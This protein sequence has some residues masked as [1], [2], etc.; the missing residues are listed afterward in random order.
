MQP[1]E[2]LMPKFADEEDLI[3]SSDNTLGS[4][5]AHSASKDLDICSLKLIGLHHRFQEMETEEGCDQDWAWLKP[6]ILHDMGAFSIIRRNTGI[7]GSPRGISLNSEF[8]AI[9][10][11]ITHAKITRAR[12]LTGESSDDIFSDER[13][14]H[15]FDIRYVTISDGFPLSFDRSRNQNEFME[16]LFL[17][18][19]LN[20]DDFIGN[21][22]SS[23]VN[24]LASYLIADSFFVWPSVVA[25]K[26]RL[27]HIS[28]WTEPALAFTM[29]YHI[30]LLRSHGHFGSQDPS[31]YHVSSEAQSQPPTN[32]QVAIIDATPNPKSHAHKTLAQ[33]QEAC[34]KY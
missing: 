21:L 5:E 16:G 29:Y 9:V 34:T 30:H 24:P 28:F 27:V 17:A 8:Y 32:T 22:P 20:V 6:D 14:L 31:E 23:D 26:H 25:K 12:S 33:S 15:G 19:P 2:Y 11:Q 3:T 18:F 4:G 13:N 1:F 7:Q 10:S